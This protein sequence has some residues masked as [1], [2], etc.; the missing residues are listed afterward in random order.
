MLTDYFKFGTGVGIG[1]KISGTTKFDEN[2]KIKMAT[3]G[4]NIHHLCDD[5]SLCSLLLV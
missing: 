3:S 1:E 2:R 4:D 5:L